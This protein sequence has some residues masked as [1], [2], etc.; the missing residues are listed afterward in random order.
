MYKPM[1]ADKALSIIRECLADGRYRV[2]RHFTKRMDRRGLFWADVLAVI[3]DPKS[4]EGGGVD[5]Y[6]RPKWIIEGKAADEL[7]LEIVCVLDHAEGDDET[8]FITLYWK[9]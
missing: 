4:V 1:D 6:H 5:K 8:V 9:D 3:D 2:L 7:P